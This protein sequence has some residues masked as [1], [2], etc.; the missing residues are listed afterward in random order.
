MQQPGD[1]KGGR[2]NLIHQC[3]ETARLTIG[4]A[5]PRNDA[6]IRRLL[7]R[8]VLGIGRCAGITEITGLISPTIAARSMHN[9]GSPPDLRDRE[10]RA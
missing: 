6:A 2:R 7:R 8:I 3:Q 5:Q 9:I 1:Q 10:Q 4:R